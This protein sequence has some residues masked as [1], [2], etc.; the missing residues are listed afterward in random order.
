[1]SE[2]TNISLYNRLIYQFCIVL[3][4]LIHIVLLFYI[5]YY[6][7]YKNSNFYL[8]LI[9]KIQSI[10]MYNHIILIITKLIIAWF[11]KSYLELLIRFG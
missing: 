3:F 5:I 9:I 11:L 7:I 6:K 10:L 2:L 4:Y 1:M 8:F